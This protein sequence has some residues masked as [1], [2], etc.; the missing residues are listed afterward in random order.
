[1]TVTHTFRVLVYAQVFLGVIA[2][3]VAELNITMVLLAGTLSVMSWYV[4]E[5][6][7]G[8]GLPRW[9]MNIGVLSITGWM[10]WTQ[11][12][13][14]KPLI[15][16]LGEFMVF[17]QLFKLYE[18]KANRDYAQLIVL[19]LMQMICAAIISAEIIFGFLLVAYMIAALFTVLTFQLKLSYDEVL[20]ASVNQTPRSY[21]AIRP[22]GVITAHH[23]RQFRTAGVTC[24]VIVLLL[25]AAMFVLL[26]RGRGKGVLG[27]WDTT[28]AR[29][30]TSGFNNK[31]ELIGNRHITTS[32]LAVMNIVVT[33]NNVPAG[34][35]EE[36][37]LLRGACLDNYSSRTRRWTRGTVV[38]A[39][40]DLS[41]PLTS[42]PYPLLHPI[43]DEPTIELDIT[44]RTQTAG[45]LFAIY[46]PLTIQSSEIEKFRFNVHDQELGLTEARDRRL[47]YRVVCGAGRPT[48][49]RKA[50]LS[51]DVG[52]ASNRPR[53][54]RA[55]WRNAPRLTGYPST[56]SQTRVFDWEDYAREPLFKSPR[57]N[58]LV[59]GILKEIHVQR[60]PSQIESPDD[61]K[62]INAMVEHL[63][64]RCTYTL[65]LPPV[66]GGADPI[67]AF[68]FDTRTGHCEYFASGLCAMLRAVGIRCRVIT[69]FRVTEYN[70]VGGY[71]VVR[72][73]NAHAW[74]EAWV[75][76]DGWTT[77]D[78]NPRE[79]IE[80]L[81]E[82]H[83]GLIAMIRDL[84]EYLEFHWINKVIT[85]D[86]QQRQSMI[87]NIDDGLDS[88]SSRF[89]AWWK[90]VV[91]WFKT[92]PRRWVL[93]GFGYALLL[94]T[95][96][97]IVAG[98]TLAIWLIIRHRRHIRQL[99]LEAV[100]RRDQ[101]RLA[102]QLEFYIQMLQ[103]VEKAGHS[104]PVWETPA[105]FAASLSE[106]DP[107][108]FAAVT[109]L[110]ELFYEIR[111]G[112]RPL[113][114]ERSKQI[115][116]QLDHLR[117]MVLR[118]MPSG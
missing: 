92:F 4:V 14:A 17:I 104:K 33:R 71:Y 38:D 34:S 73:K 55:G 31:V 80:R 29:P 78:P 54:E 62:I 57:L 42:E 25:S 43:P 10:F 94:V 32:N 97:L 36:S 82:P 46:P 60:D 106:K 47:R 22:R 12:K 64:N 102:Q 63:Q 58:L 67:E 108:R 118:T 56:P 8:R 88:M 93:G 96:G 101:K 83:H 59:Q 48:D 35:E 107:M 19:S 1:M 50:Y 76:G 116:E 117:H 27:D 13:Q 90:S 61:A 39:Y 2:Y 114:D 103:I 7:G 95:A 77:V 85:Y 41:Q 65:D 112:G 89:A 21:Q 9:L 20:E 86:D 28:T 79:A 30:T 70:S 15:V 115:T 66:P 69:G 11:V 100:S 23:R 18:R 87:S 111:F 109:P 72:Q 99:Q 81:H 51:P 68:L 45:T 53:N 40:E 113:N 75:P 37:F 52:Y 16:A 6:P 110:T 105:S 26:P 91:E 84:Y 24:G 44:L 49:L 5:G 98:I 74:V 3:S